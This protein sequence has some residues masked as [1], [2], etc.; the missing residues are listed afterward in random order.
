MI[1]F[2][3]QYVNQI[4][5]GQVIVSKKV[6]DIYEKLEKEKDNEACQYYYDA[7]VGALPIEFIERFC[8]QS[9]GTLGAPIVLDLW[10]K[11][12]IQ[13]LFGWL[14]KKTHKRRFKETMLLVGRKNGKTTLLSAIALYMM[15]AD[16][17]GG[18]ECYS[19]ATKK[20]QAKKA[21]KSACNM[22]AQ[23]PQLLRYVK[24]RQS[25]LYMKSTFSTFEPLASDSNTLDGL[26][27]HLGIIDELHAIKDRNLYEVIQQSTSSREQPL[28]V[29]I[30]TCGTVRECIYDDIYDYAS[31][32]IY[33]PNGFSDDRFL[34]MLYE[35]D[36][37]EEWTNESAWYKANPSLNSIKKLSYLRDK[38]KSAINDSKN[39]SGVLTKDFNVRV[40]GNESWLTFQDVDN[41][42]TFEMEELRG[43][44]AVGGVD[45]SSTTDL[46]CA[47]V[48]VM[49]SDSHIKCLQHYFIPNDNLET[50]IIEDK[51]PYDKWAKRGL[52][53]LCDGSRVDY[54][55]VTNWFV[56]LRDT[57]GI[58]VLW[59][60]YDTWGSQYWATEM[61]QNGFVLE[62]VIQGAK[63][64]STPMKE[65][66][67]DF[68][69]RKIN[70][71]NNPILKWCLC[72]TKIK[73]DDN[74]NIRPVKKGTRQRIDGAVALIDA[75]VTLKNHYDDYINLL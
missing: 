27:T 60:G 35:L 58:Y 63:T 6:N 4:R 47:T 68:Q 43:C 57:Y 66:K 56:T 14:D 15:I 17:E 40:N 65:L 29:M 38:V 5:S 30:T 11:A 28:L 61:K 12:Y 32:C 23:S 49:D 69:E 74:D 16:G 1:D 2:V 59:T 50:K 3:K 51:I 44:Y 8:K 36:N 72:N 13:T 70:Y 41:V 21:F 45:L 73:V 33:E 26:N 39:L 46:T 62:S 10:Q 71:N 55:D 42:A 20:D 19:V 54:S 22:V 18:A 64:M 53:T 24:K 37:M 31:N 7:K 67:A 25:D 34:P 75:Y 9:E 48:L 52:I